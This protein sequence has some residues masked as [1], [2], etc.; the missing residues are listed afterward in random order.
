M[1]SSDLV[2]GLEQR[3]ELHSPDF[4]HDPHRA[5]RQMRE[6][7]GR[8]VPVELAPGVPA[9]LVIGYRTGLAIL[10]DPDRF[11]T[12]PRTWEPSVPPECPVLP[13]MRWR[14]SA[15]RTTGFEHARL[16]AAVSAALDEV[17]L[18]GV[19]AIVER[20]ATPL[21]NAFCTTGS[22][23]LVTQYAGPVVFMVINH[24]LGCPPE[25]S[26]KAAAGIA[27]ILDGGSD[28]EEGN[29]AFESALLELMELKR[30]TPGTDIASGL[31]RH[32]DTLDDDEILQQLIMF[33]GIGMEAAQS[34][35]VTALW[36]LLTDD[37]F[38]GSIVSGVLSTRDA[39]DSVLFE[40]PPLPNI[41]FSYP[42]QPIM[43]DDVWLPAHQPVVVSFAGCNSD[44][45]IAAG[46][47]TGNRAHLAWGAGPHACPAKSLGYLIAQC[48][49]DQL[50]DALP[51][52]ELAVAADA[53]EWRPGWLQRALAALP[54]AFPPS[55]PL[56]S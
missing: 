50:L 19:H 26:Q 11:P 28:A 2:N 34:L 43:M 44:P 6:R 37:R 39:L 51:E 29:R 49:V 17:D 21:I 20:T 35:I 10:N 3:V 47:R 4:S 13:A 16:R 18:H 5:Y 55:P 27:A 52:L 56:P 40:D 53:L 54:V 48:A 23:E 15:S 32:G 8:L 36:L 22:A 45:E 46:D 12:D 24:L 42:R 30:T 25:I 33:Y 9:T 38:G 41:S 1:E 31:L 7:F 14:P